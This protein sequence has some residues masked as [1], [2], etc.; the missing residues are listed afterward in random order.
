MHEK[1]KWNAIGFE[2]KTKMLYN[3]IKK[4]KDEIPEDHL[5]NHRKLQGFIDHLEYIIEKMKRIQSEL[6][7]NLEQIFKLK[8]KTPEL[9]LISLCRPSIRNI[10]QDLEI[11]LE[12]QPH[13]P[14]NIDDYKEL[15]SLGDA[16]NVL[17]LVGDAALDLSVVQTLWDSSLATVGRLTL[18]RQGIVANDNLARICDQWKLYEYRLNR[19]NDLSEQNAKPKTI[20]HEKGTLIESIYGVIYLEFGF[21]VLVRTIPLIQ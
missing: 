8:F 5:V 4:E 17:A 21:E 2:N 10:Y 15:A 19:L 11:H 14:L 12:G 18:R 7:P 16:A 20:Q 6:I 3:S 1:L 9:I 13:N